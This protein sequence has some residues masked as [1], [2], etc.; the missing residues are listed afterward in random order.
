MSIIE[1][2]STFG[3]RRIVMGTAMIGLVSGAM[4]AF[5]YLRRQ[6]LL[7]GVIGHSATPGVMG[8]FVLVSVL[9]PQA[10]ARSMP[11]VVVG[12][13]ITGLASAL[14]ANRI[15]ATTR[16]GIDATMAVMFSLFLGGGLLI[17]QVIQNSTLPDKG[18]IE[19]FMFGNATR[20]S[21]LDVTTIFAVAVLV[22]ALLALLWRPFSLMTFDVVFS[23]S[24]G[25][26][27][28]WLSPLLF[29]LIVLAMVI[30]IKAVGLILMIAFAVFPP[31]A[32]RQFTTTLRQMTIASAV[33]G[34]VCGVVGSYISIAVGDI[35]TGPTIVVVLGVAVVISYVLGKLVRT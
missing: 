24:V 33:I 3:Y 12:A 11:V 18:G 8:A 10:D 17:L 34:A 27:L 32:A 16:I 30:G 4:G 19:E 6:S 26:P 21:N 29:G 22:L 23:R 31:A 15:A 5:L 20:L 9:L 13:L 14:L 25:L 28:R 7:S 35:P 1:F 2:L